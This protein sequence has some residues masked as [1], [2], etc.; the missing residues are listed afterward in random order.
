MELEQLTLEEAREL[1]GLTDAIRSNLEIIAGDA[2]PD[3]ELVELH[4]RTSTIV[5]NLRIIGAADANELE[6]LERRVA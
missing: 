3:A 4:R 2:P 1:R 5:E 6:A